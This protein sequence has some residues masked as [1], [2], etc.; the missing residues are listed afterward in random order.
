MLV[1]A[2]SNLLRHP[3][4]CSIDVAGDVVL[5]SISSIK[6]SPCGMFGCSAR[7]PRPQPPS[8]TATIP[9]TSH[10]QP[11]QPPPPR[12]PPSRRSR[13]RPLRGRRFAAA[14]CGGWAA[15]GAGAAAGAVP[16]TSQRVAVGLG[17][18]GRCRRAVLAR[19]PARWAW[20]FTFVSAGVYICIRWCLHLYPL[21]AAVGCG[22]HS[23][24]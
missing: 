13:R 7:R 15:G 10:A 6:N 5:A 19:W 21:A 1:W 24:P 4:G 2:L 8:P 18:W 9:R 23:P 14:G 20:M 12:L 11:P 22:C 16:R 17:G 3:V